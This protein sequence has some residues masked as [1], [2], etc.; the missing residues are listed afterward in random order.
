MFISSSRSLFKAVFLT[1]R[2]RE[3]EA[4]HRQ[5]RGSQLQTGFIYFAAVSSTLVRNNNI[6]VWT[7]EFSGRVV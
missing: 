7:G 2:P 4:S 5:E 3:P 6:N 1:P